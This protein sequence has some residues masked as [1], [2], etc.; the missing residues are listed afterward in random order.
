LTNAVVEKFGVSL[1]EAEQIKRVA[2]RSR[3][4]EQIMRVLGPV[5]DEIASEIQRSLGYYKSLAREVKFERAVMLGSAL[6]MSGAAKM[7]ASRLQYP[8]RTLT[9]LS[10]IRFAAS[11]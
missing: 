8:V 2:G 7:M 4:R 10:S 3:H 9:E 6:R 11:V 5:F 1:E